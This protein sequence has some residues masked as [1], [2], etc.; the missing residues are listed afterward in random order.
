MAAINVEHVFN[1]VGNTGDTGI[2]NDIF[3]A[4]A[5]R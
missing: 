4:K 3:S 1:F 2:L 5:E